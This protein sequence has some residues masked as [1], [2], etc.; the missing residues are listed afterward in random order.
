MSALTQGL[1]QSGLVAL[2]ANSIGYLITRLTDTHKITDLVGTGSFVATALA[3]QWRTGVYT[4]RAL[5]MTGAIS[6][7]GTRLASFLFARVLKQG[8]DARLGAVFKKPG[9]MEGFWTIQAA[10]AWICMVPHTLLLYG[11]KSMAAGSAAMAL[12][13][14][15]AIAATIMIG[16]IVFESVADWQKWKH[17]FDPSKKG[18]FCKTGL[19]SL[20]RQPNYFGELCTWWGGYFLALPG[21][22]AGPWGWKAAALGVVSP[23]WIQFLLLFVSGIPLSEK[24]NEKKYGQ[25]EEYKQ[26]KKDTPLLIPKISNAFKSSKQ[27]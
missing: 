5:L 17:R 21:L 12:G 10:W 13:P 23:L 27:S 7:W 9:G 6:F 16:G 22:L 20:C 24:G 18:T 8:D 19:W 25:M 11:A 26:Y 15:D 4:P 3:T 14:L 2:G 1:I